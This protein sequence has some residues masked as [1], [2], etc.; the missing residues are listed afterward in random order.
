[1]S[2]QS[3]DCTPS[4]P[5][6]PAVSLQPGGSL[7]FSSTGTFTGYMR[8]QRSRD[9]GATWITIQTAAQDTNLAG[10][11][12]KNESKAEERY[13]F[14]LFAITEAGYDAAGDPV[15]EDPATGTCSTV[16]TDDIEA[17][18]DSASTP[19]K[20]I[21][22]NAAGQSKAGATAGWVVAAGSN[23]ALVTLPASQTGSTLVV[24]LPAFEVGTKIVG[25][26]LV[27]QHEGAGGAGTT[28]DADLRKHTVAATDVADASVGAITQLAL[29]ADAILSDANTRKGDLAEVVSATETYYVLVTAT[30]PAGND[31]A[32]QGVVLEI[33]EP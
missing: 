18:V 13:R 33:I 8:F 26:H 22:V 6:S 3:F 20:H 9:H 29:G 30:T 7:Q 16:L 10:G 31:I 25:F 27:G 1:M 19:A 28:I 23:I 5:F 14:G 12:V 4:A 15:A 17:L 11:T 21:V 24:P 32:L 2:T